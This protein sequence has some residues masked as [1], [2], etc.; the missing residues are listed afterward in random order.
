MLDA[1]TESM[2]WL[3]VGALLLLGLVGTIVPFLPGTPLIVVAALVHAAATGW[4]PIGAGRLTILAALAGF[5][6]ALHYFAGALGA[7]RAGGSRWAV[8]GALVGGVVGL[9]FGLPGVLLGPPLG[10]I[11]GQLLQSGNLATSVRTGIL[12]LIGMVA[13]AVANFTIAVVMI[14]L[15]LWWVRRG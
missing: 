7:R 4:T 14:A 15:F 11:A 10:A 13:G 8:V 12:A 1:M 2:L 6:Y 9:F 3:G 5:G